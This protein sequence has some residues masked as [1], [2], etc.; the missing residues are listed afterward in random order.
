VAFVSKNKKL[1]LAIIDGWN[2]K[3]TDDLFNERVFLELGLK[4]IPSRHTFLRDKE[5]KDALVQKK[6]EIRKRKKE[7]IHEINLTFDN[8]DKIK[9]FLK[10]SRH[11]DSVINEFINQLQKLEKDN[12]RLHSETKRLT[13]QNNILLERFAR[14]QYN[15]QKM[16]GVDLNKLAATIDVGLPAKNR[17]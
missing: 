11:D 4:K 16:D 3:L 15:L 14:W 12:G 9:E 10:N 8:P 17:L 2:G 7:A 6:D 1:I 13:A 5:I